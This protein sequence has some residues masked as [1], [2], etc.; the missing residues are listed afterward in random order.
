MYSYDA[1]IQLNHD[2]PIVFDE[3][4]FA[5]RAVHNSSRVTV[6]VVSISQ[7]TDI[8]LPSPVCYA[9]LALRVYSPCVTNFTAVVPT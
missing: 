1:S 9:L 6:A 2:I 8:H 4:Q 3:I 5:N 7:N